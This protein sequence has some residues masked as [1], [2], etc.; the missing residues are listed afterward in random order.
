[1]KRGEINI[2]EIMDAADKTFKDMT[3]RYGPLQE[4]LKTGGVQ[5][6]LRDPQSLL[7]SLLPPEQTAAFK[8]Q[9]AHGL[10][11]SLIPEAPAGLASDMQARLDAL[12]DGF[13]IALDALSR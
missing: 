6:F 12:R 8:E 9:V 10:S 5:A 4:Q 13:P 3:A 2:A 11:G 1:M 7:D